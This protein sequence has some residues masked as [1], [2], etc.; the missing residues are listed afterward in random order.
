MVNDY[1]KVELKMVGIQNSIPETLYFDQALN[2][3]H[4]EIM[5]LLAL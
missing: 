2:I 1:D 5:Y 4:W 3:N